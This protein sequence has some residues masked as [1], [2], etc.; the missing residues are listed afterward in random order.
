MDKNNK[1]FGI[2]GKKQ[3][4]KENKDEFKRDVA[5][6]NYETIELFKKVY[7]RYPA[8]D[9][10]EIIKNNSINMIK[11]EQER[12]KKTRPIRAALVALSLPIG[13]LLGFFGKHKLLNS[14]DI[15]PKAQEAT[16]ENDG[17]I[18]DLED[19]NTVNGI[20]QTVVSKFRSELQDMSNYQTDTRSNI[21]KD[22]RSIDNKEDALA[23]L[24][25]MMSE[26]YNKNS[27]EQN[28]IVTVIKSN[29]ENK[30]QVLSTDTAEN[31]DKIV[32]LTS[33]NTAKEQG[34]SPMINVNV[35]DVCI[36]TGE[37]YRHEKVTC[38]NGEYIPVYDG[39]KEIEREEKTQLCDMGHLVSAGLKWVDN[40]NDVTSQ[41][42]FAD[43][44]K[45]YTLAN[46]KSQDS[47]N[48]EQIKQS[49]IDSIDEERE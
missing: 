38:V 2:K 49:I 27:S 48:Q 44:V 25:E 40:A 37:E 9:E 39:T 47:N 19:E 41:L 8:D 15:T 33:R 28:E 3:G 18:E 45:K 35:I 12:Y 24:K 17:K 7:D 1:K 36:K 23:Y 10:K 42:G 21:E 29:I 46:E 22:I 16:K 32:R 6:E 4:N 14:G 30:G 5:R 20:T 11:K 34:Y 13:M 43:E 31:G 26:E